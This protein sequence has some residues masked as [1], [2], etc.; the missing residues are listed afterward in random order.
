MQL[1]DKLENIAQKIRE[2]EKLARIALYEQEDLPAYRNLLYEK[3]ELLMTVRDLAYQ[4]GI[5]EEV[6]ETL[7][8]FSQNAEQA[9]ELQSL[10]YMQ[11]LLYPDGYK[12]GSPNNLELVIQELGAGES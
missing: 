10:F 2:L 11:A 9:I 5:S 4:P 1:V 7:L 3:A 12:E 6:A 8:Q